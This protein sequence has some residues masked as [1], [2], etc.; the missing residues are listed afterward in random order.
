MTSDKQ[1]LQDVTCTKQCWFLQLWNSWF[2]PES[3]ILII[4]I[5]SIS[6]IIMIIII[7]AFALEF[8]PNTD[9]NKTVW[10]GS[11]FN[12]YFFVLF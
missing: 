10:E 3:F 7:I 12:I 6:F 4:I 9:S 2:N 8:T 11:C 5:T 1:L